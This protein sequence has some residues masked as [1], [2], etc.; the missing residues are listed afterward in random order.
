MHHDAE[1]DRSDDHRNQLQKGVAEDLEPDG[2]I[3]RRHAEHNPEQ[4]RRQD[5]NEK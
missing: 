5:L 4:Q 3:R 2:K 1:H